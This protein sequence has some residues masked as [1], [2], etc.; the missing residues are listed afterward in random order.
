MFSKRVTQARVP[1][2]QLLSSQGRGVRSI[3]CSNLDQLTHSPISPVPSIPSAPFFCRWQSTDANAGS[4]CRLRTCVFCYN[5]TMSIKSDNPGCSINFEK[6]A[7]N[8][9]RCG[10]KGSLVQYEAALAQLPKDAPEKLRNVYQMAKNTY[11]RRSGIDSSQSS[12]A[13]STF[14][15]NRSMNQHS[16][17]SSFVSNSPGQIVTRS[18]LPSPQANP[19]KPAANIPIDPIAANLTAQLELPFRALQNQWPEQSS[20]SSQ[21]T[22]PVV[23]FLK[24]RGLTRETCMLYKVGATKVEVLKGSEKILVDAVTFPYYAR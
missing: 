2:I 5:K 18:D 11:L 1:L 20:S 3:P 7:F 21:V 17:H 14:G 19:A 12:R 9:F 8:C 6:G 23:S 4:W 22:S 13:F 16:H 24:K 10:C 15:D